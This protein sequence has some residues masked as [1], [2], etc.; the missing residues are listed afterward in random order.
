MWEFGL[1]LDTPSQELNDD[2]VKNVTLVKFDGSQAE[3]IAWQG[4]PPSGHR[5]KELL[6][7]DAIVPLSSTLEMRIARAGERNPRSFRWP[8]K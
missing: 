3:P 6:R 4:D 8:L 1:V 5:R 7:F 2:L